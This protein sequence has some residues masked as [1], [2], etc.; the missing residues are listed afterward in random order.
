MEFAT[1]ILVKKALHVLTYFT[2][3]TRMNTTRIARA[4]GMA[5]IGAALI[6][7]CSKDSSVD[8]SDTPPT[9]INPSTGDSVVVQTVKAIVWPSPNQAE[10]DVLVDSAYVT[11]NSSCTVKVK[12]SNWDPY[13]NKL[14]TVSFTLRVPPGAVSSPKMISITVDKNAPEITAEFGPSGTVFLTP[15]LLDV[16]A[17][18]IDLTGFSPSDH[19]DLW[20]V[21]ASGWV[22][23]MQYDR[24]MFDPTRAWLLVTDIQIPHF[25]RYCFGR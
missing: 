3:S 15:A 24:F 13:H 14:S 20:Y 11:P 7:G 16:Q 21:N 8:P 22:G 5:L 12:W 10:T 17:S 23:T 2:G 25:S 19:M 1:K 18:G 9:A 6:S 4:L